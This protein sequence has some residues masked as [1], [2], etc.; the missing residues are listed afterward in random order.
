M[1][2]AG[3]KRQNMHYLQKIV[4]NESEKRIILTAHAINVRTPAS[5]VSAT[6]GKIYKL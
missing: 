6:L 1:K 2:W 3:I 5:A 4:E